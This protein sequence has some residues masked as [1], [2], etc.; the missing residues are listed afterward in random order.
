VDA[1]LL[2]CA[3]HSRVNG[4]C[5]YKTADG[6]ADLPLCWQFSDLE[7]KLREAD[8]GA[9]HQVASAGSERSNASRFPLS[10]AAILAAS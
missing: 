8:F 6:D 10:R 2:L 9:I 1:T 3:W 5:A 4:I 7:T